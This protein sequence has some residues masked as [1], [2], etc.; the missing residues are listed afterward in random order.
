MGRARR[1]PVLPHPRIIRRATVSV[2]KMAAVWAHPGTLSSGERLVLL[3]LADHADGDGSCY[4]SVARIASMA[5][6]AD[7][8][9]RKH[10]TA[11]EARGMIDRVRRRRSDGSLGTYQYSVL[12]S[13]NPTGT[14]VPVADPEPTGTQGPPYRYSRVHPTGTQVP[15]LTITEPPITIYAAETVETEPPADRKTRVPTVEQLRSSMTEKDRDK[16][17]DTY[18]DRSFEELE[19][20]RDYH[21]ARGMK[22]IDWRATLRNWRQNATRYGQ[23]QPAPVMSAAERLV[24]IQRGTA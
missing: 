14:P 20:F 2:T 10:L 15:R 24:E 9:V 16:W 8:Q 3:A 17:R 13:E 12:P 11:L 18:G 23:A 21:L 4:P 1:I 7:R 6:I 5:C 19:R 22:R